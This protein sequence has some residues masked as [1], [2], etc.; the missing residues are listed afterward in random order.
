MDELQ[1]MELNIEEILK[2]FAT[3][4]QTIKQPDQNDPQKINTITKE[5]SDKVI[6]LEGKVI[7]SDILTANYDT[8]ERENK[9]L[10]E[11]FQRVFQEKKELEDKLSSVKQMLESFALE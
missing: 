3:L 4:V 5:L 7:N 8:L 9:I 10:E 11:N 2:T 1:S 6:R